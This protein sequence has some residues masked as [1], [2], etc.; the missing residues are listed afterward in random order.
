VIWNVFKINYNAK[1]DTW[2]MFALIPV[3]FDV[4]FGCVNYDSPPSNGICLTL[5]SCGLAI[6]LFSV[7]IQKGILA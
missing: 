2:R 6:L 5:L 4:T 1:K 3:D 7:E